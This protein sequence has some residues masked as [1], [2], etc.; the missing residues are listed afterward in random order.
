[1]KVGYNVQ[2]F[3]QPGRTD[4]MTRHWLMVVA[5]VAAILPTAA[6]ATITETDF[7]LHTTADLVNLC[8]ASP[9]EPMGTAALN[10]CHGFAVGV[11]RVLEEEN[12]AKRIGRLFCTP[13]AAT[14]SRNEAIA[15]FVQWAKANAN[16][17]S[18]PPADGI[19]GYL[20]QKYPCPRGK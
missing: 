5:T 2:G 9:S 13:E 15:D 6:D 3:E 11:Y 8:S 20:A 1:M 14:Q 17:M 18:Q 19:T 7:Q 10:F 4:G 12:A 16:T